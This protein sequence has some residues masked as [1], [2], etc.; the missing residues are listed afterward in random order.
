MATSVELRAKRATVWEQAKAI[1][2]AAEAEDRNLTAEEDANWKKANADIAVYDERIERVEQAERTP[3]VQ[4]G[5]SVAGEEA[6]QTAAGTGAAEEAAR[7]RGEA[8]GAWIRGGILNLEPEQRQAMAAY[9]VQPGEMRAM[10]VGVNSAG[11]YW[12]PDEMRRQMETA[13]LAYGGMREAGTVMQTAT[14]NDLAIPTD[15][16]TSN[17]GELVGEHQAVTEQDVAIGQVIYRAYMYSSK[18]VKVSIELLQDSV[19]DVEAFLREK[20]T[21]RIGRITNTH[22]TTGTGADRPTGITQDSVL[23]KTAAATGAVTTDE[24]I[25]LEFSVDRAYRASARWMLHSNTL[26]DLRKL[27]DGDGRYIWQPGMQSGNPN[28]LNGYGYIVNDDMPTMATGNRAIEFGQLGKY[29]IRDVSGFRVIRL[30]ERYA[31]NGQVA[32]FAFFRC[33]GKLLDAGTNPVKHI[34]MA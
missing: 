3:A 27:K 13:L 7:Q 22:F 14:G 4:A 17:V 12:V 11:G 23:G 30:D 24:L 34:V 16:D 8:F 25:D 33:D 15:N 32:F 31:E 1:L 18:E 19:F 21:E 9:R 26:R 10:G 29:L 28:S 6:R 2:D 20:F 5:R